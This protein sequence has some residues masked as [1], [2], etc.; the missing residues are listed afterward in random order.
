M[1]TRTDRNQVFAA[2][3]TLISEEVVVV[4]TTLETNEVS[5]R[6]QA[7]AALTTLRTSVDTLQAIVDKTNANIGP[8]DTKAVARETRR[9]A[10]QM[11]AITRLLVGALEST[12]TGTE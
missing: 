4:D 6:N 1:S 12:D 8:A 11:I 9:V 7:L 2:D 3:G 5:L 10:R